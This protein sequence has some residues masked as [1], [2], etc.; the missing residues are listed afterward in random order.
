M[1]KKRFRKII[2]KLLTAIKIKFFQQS[3]ITTLRYNPIGGKWCLSCT[4]NKQD[5]TLSLMF[6][7]NNKHRQ[8]PNLSRKVIEESVEDN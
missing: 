7:N 5:I 3:S 6:E 8:K 2:F 4:D 1:F